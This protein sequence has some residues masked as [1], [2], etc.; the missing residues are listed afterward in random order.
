MNYFNLYKFSALKKDWYLNFIDHFNNT[1]DFVFQDDIELIDDIDYG[2]TLETFP[3][4]HGENFQQAIFR[5]KRIHKPR[6]YK[7]YIYLRFH[8]WQYQKHNLQ[9]QNE[10]GTQENLVYHGKM[11]PT[12]FYEAH[13]G[14]QRYV[15][16]SDDKTYHARPFLRKRFSPEQATPYNLVS[17]VRNAIINDR[18]D[19]DPNSDD[20]QPD[21]PSPYL[22]SPKNLQRA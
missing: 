13:V 21:Q 8:S 10:S 7:V 3:T 6:N 4:E 1:I 2:D 5:C 19:D 16:A 20:E 14:I 11:I 15:L 12:E 9:Y 22:N 17:F 18:F